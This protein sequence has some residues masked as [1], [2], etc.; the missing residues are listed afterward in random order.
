MAKKD[1]LRYLKVISA[2]FLLGL[3]PLSKLDSKEVETV[4]F[5]EKDK[6]AQKWD[7]LFTDHTLINFTYKNQPLAG[8][9]FLGI[10]SKGDYFL[11]S[12]TEE[13]IM[14]FDS[15][16]NFIRFIG[17]K[18]QGPGEYQGIGNLF[19][20][21]EDNLYLYDLSTRCVS[22]FTYPDY[23]FLKQTHP[24]SGVNKIFIDSQGNFITFS[25]YNIANLL[26]KYNKSGEL[27]A[28]TFKAEDDR[29]RAAMARFNPGGLAN[30]PDLGFLFVYPDKYYIY[31]YD[32]D[33]TLKKIFKPRHFS[34]F[35]PE[36]DSFPQDLDPRDPAYEHSNWWD[37]FLHPGDIYF[38]KDKFFLV[39]LW[40]TKGRFGKNYINLHDLN[41]VTYARGLEIPY[42]GEIS[43]ARGDYVYIM[44]E[45]KLAGQDQFI[46]AKLH[47]YKLSV[48]EK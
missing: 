8:F 27:M 48:P 22:I 2:L 15:A 10:N 46:P 45:E 5:K 25:L 42:E 21:R 20:D 36:A 17:S 37:K 24:K 41:G 29:L 6:V 4:F 47:R 34:K 19:F 7:E 23:H 11:F 39:V 26:K 12:R 44:E 1:F 31:F 32:Y 43:C 30:V 38:L 13:K 18:G 3:C 14:Q 33:F 9:G 28:E 40:E 35:Y 16:G